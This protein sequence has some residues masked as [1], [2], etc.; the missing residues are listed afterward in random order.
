VGETLKAHQAG[1]FSW[2]KVSLPVLVDKIASQ[3][4]LLEPPFID[5]IIQNK[6]EWELAAEPEKQK[7]RMALKDYFI[8]LPECGYTF[9]ANL[10]Q[11][12]PTFILF[13]QTMD[14][15][16]GWFGYTETS[17]IEKKLATFIKKNND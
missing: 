11:G 17:R 10:M 5:S 6:R 15:L 13:N 9:A 4:D 16:L 8:Q 1:L 3:T 2:K 14:I 7:V 12:T